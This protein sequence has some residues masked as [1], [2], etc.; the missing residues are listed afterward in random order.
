MRAVGYAVAPRR[1]IAV[2]M[3]AFF[4]RWAK[5]IIGQ[6]H[7]KTTLYLYSEGIGKVSGGHRTLGRVRTTEKI[8]MF[9]ITQK[10]TKLC[11]E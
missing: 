9:G 11:R 10:I 8:K 1:R 2:Q 3:L 7:I 5:S 4:R 6:E